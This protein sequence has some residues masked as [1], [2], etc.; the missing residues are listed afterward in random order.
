M[1][2]LIPD[3]VSSGTIAK[4]RSGSIDAGV[5]TSAVINFAL[6]HV[7]ASFTVY[8]QSITERTIAPV[9]TLRV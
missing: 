3:L 5:R 6:V 2:G 8:G 7:Q 9:A 4:E 1:A